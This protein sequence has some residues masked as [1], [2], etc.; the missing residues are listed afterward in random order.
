MRC[1][2]CSCKAS[3]AAV[4]KTCNSGSESLHGLVSWWHSAVFAQQ[5]KILRSSQ[6]EG[7]LVLDCESL[8]G[9]GEDSA[10]IEVRDADCALVTAEE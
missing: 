3:R 8:A 5:D 1:I 4:E 7:V 9:R 6:I 10:M 2:V